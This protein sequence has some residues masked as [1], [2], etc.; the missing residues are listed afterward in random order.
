[1]H[2]W[3]GARDLLRAPGTNVLAVKVS[4]RRGM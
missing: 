1:M 4:Y 2:G 3:A